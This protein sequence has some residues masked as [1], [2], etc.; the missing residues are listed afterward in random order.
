MQC[1]FWYNKNSKQNTMVKLINISLLPVTNFVE[2]RTLTGYFIS[3]FQMH[4]SVLG[5]IISVLYARSLFSFSAGLGLNSVPCVCEATLPP[6]PLHQ[7]MCWSTI[8]HNWNFVLFDPRLL[9]PHLIPTSQGVA[10]NAVS[11]S[12]P[13]TAGILTQLSKWR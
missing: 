13:P 3:K 9:L 6:E 10:Q 7:P 8:A 11:Y 4:T 5:T 1:M 2:V 12:R